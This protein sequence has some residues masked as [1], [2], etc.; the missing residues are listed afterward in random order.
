MPAGPARDWPW[1]CVAVAGTGFLTAPALYAVAAAVSRP[2][3]A[4]VRGGATGLQSSALS[5]GFALGSPLAGTAVGPVVPYDLGSDCGRG[6]LAW[7]VSW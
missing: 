3:P 5:A 4:S 6:M 1:L 2:A 7:R